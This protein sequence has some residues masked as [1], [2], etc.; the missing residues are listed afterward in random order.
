MSRRQSAGRQSVDRHARLS[1]ERRRARLE[2]RCRR[3]LWLYPAEHRRQHG[4]EMLDV[5][6]ASA[7]AGPL[8]RTADVADLVCGAVR[9]RSR[10]LG[11]RSRTASSR[12]RDLLRRG[13][14]AVRSLCS[15][16]R[17]QRWA[18]AFDVVSVIAPVLL[19]I[20]ALSQFN[21]PQATASIATG[22]PFLPFTGGFYVADWPL[23]IGAPAI[24]VL[25]AVRL[26]R[27]AGLAGL[28]TGL[29]QLFLLPALGDSD[30]AS[31]ALAFSVLLSL[32][33]GTALLM[34]PRGF[35]GGLAVLR[36]WGFGAV[37][38]TGLVL[39]GLSLGVVDLPWTIVVGT[40]YDV[41]QASSAV[42]SDAM[43]TLLPAEIAG[44]PGDI[45]IGLVL[46]MAAIACLFRPV[47]RRILALLAIPLIPYTIIWQDKLVAD[48]IGQLNVV[49]P[50]TL[51]TLYVVPL[52]LAG[53]IVA[54]TRL[55]RRRVTT[56]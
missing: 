23:T 35:C 29:T 22:H 53:L 34:S 7:S 9:L 11:R 15:G 27:L 48:L 37:T 8:G 1:M 18:A 49:V 56:A 10:E 32:T 50:A 33:A 45:V 39:G 24:V 3:L 38:A 17:D 16:V 51:L 42:S 4:E 55:T 41:T 52:L 2:R 6:L 28:V 36:W 21:V 30:Y 5:L 43:A 44:L 12:G 19:L 46:G 20:A 13:A 26:R 14:L 25:A 40:T 54:A 31:P 47:P